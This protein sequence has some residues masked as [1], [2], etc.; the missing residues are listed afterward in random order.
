MLFATIASLGFAA[1]ATRQNAKT[2]G[3]ASKNAQ[4]A[5]DQMDEIAT[6]SRQTMQTTKAQLDR[7]EA[8]MATGTQIMF[9]L[10]DVAMELS[11]P[12]MNAFLESPTHEKG[13]LP[14]VVENVGKSPARNVTVKFNPPLPEPDVD[15][16]NANTSELVEYRKSPVALTLAKYED[17]K[18]KTWAPN[19]STSVPFWAT[20]VER[21]PLRE[22]G[23]SKRFVNAD[24]TP[25]DAVLK[26]K[27]SD[28]AM[29]LNESGDGIP[30]DVEVIITYEDDNGKKYEDSVS[31][32]PV[33]WVST[34]FRSKE[35]RSSS[36]TYGAD[37]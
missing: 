9:G 5:A 35:H 34:T 18:F 15:R 37:D 3:E 26:R 22:V 11:R 10:D 33:L 30:A 14:L 25:A 29:L 24:G 6:A 28:G 36:V 27:E 17:K 1:F 12:R 2:A 13:Y 21:F 23:E 8:M 32:N 7:L 4:D 20:K 16:L 31:L 19:Q